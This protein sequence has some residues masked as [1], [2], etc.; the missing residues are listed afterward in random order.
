MVKGTKCSGVL[1][2]LAWLGFRKGELS[3]LWVRGLVDLSVTSR[4]LTADWMDFWHRKVSCFFFCWSCITLFKILK[5]SVERDSHEHTGHR[6][7]DLSAF[8]YL[9]EDCLNFYFIDW[10]RRCLN[11]DPW[12]FWEV[13]CC[14]N[15]ALELG[16]SCLTFGDMYDLIPAPLEHSLLSVSLSLLPEFCEYCSR[17]PLCVDIGWGNCFWGLCEVSGS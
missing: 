5:Y 17:V 6:A 2:V 16:I 9:F 13:I 10:Q 8:V 12:V 3:N 11:V 7:I 15:A 4:S 14:I 1:L